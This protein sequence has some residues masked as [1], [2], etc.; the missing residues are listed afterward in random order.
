MG[1]SPFGKCFTNH[2]VPAPNPSPWN[3]RLIE[4]IQFQNAYLL[5]VKYGNCTNFEGIKLMVYRGQYN[6]TCFL[7]PHF[8]T[9]EN[10]PIARFKPDL[11]GWDLA[12]DFAMNYKPIEHRNEIQKT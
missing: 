11:E 9:T 5:K 7:D 12:I 4:N 8:D 2:D 3:W 6:P 10:S 1:I